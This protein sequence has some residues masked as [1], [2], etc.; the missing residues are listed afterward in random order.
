MTLL[1]VAGLSIVLVAITWYFAII[2][3]E[4]V[5]VSVLPF[6]GVILTGMGLSATAAALDPG[7]LT[8]TLGVLSVFMGG[9][10]LYLLSLRRMPDGALIA[11]VGQPMPALAATDDT[12]QPFDLA[13]LRGRRVMVKFFRGSW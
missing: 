5:P 1:A 9:F 4:R 7:L 12:G 10:I 6:A 3:T 11:A 8:V 2:H 13:A